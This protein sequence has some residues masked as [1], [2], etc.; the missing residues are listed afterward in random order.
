MP[1]LCVCVV[2]KATM[3]ADI[4]TM[5]PDD[6][7]VTA[8]VLAKGALALGASVPF[9]AIAKRMLGPAADEIAEMMRDQV[10]RY[11]YGR[12]LACVQ[13][14][15]KMAEDAGFTPNEVPSKLLFP[16]LEGASFEENE[17]LHTMWAALLANASSP[18]WTDGVRPS[19]IALL[20]QM[21]SD[22]AALLNWLYMNALRQKEPSH[23][24]TI[25]WYVPDLRS[26]YRSLVDAKP[27]TAD[28]FHACLDALEGSF[29][30]ERFAVAIDDK[31]IPKIRL[32][33]R[34]INLAGA[35]TPPKPV[36]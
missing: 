22:E 25:E 27:K 17:D 11:R 18:K 7:V 3:E 34:G 31:G 8:P 19:Y 30:I 6:L 15:A 9:T 16:L 36:K 26:T 20:K 21:A 4:T 32:T 33:G 28:Y 13:K 14:A 23:A 5:N 35:C 24:L 29:L 12:Q 1:L 10:R 2:F